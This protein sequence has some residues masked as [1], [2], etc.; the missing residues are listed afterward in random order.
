MAL[1]ALQRLDAEDELMSLL[2]DCILL[3]HE[4]RDRM[5]QV[6]RPD[7]EA[8]SDEKLLA[9]T[10]RLRT[11]VSEERT[12]LALEAAVGTLAAPAEAV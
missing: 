5:M 6:K 2:V 8:F 7:A 10:D 12:R 11:W 3:R 9:L 1:N 4:H